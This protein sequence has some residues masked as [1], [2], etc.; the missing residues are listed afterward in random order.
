M[1]EV[2]FLKDPRLALAVGFYG[3]SA[4]DYSGPRKEFFRLCL[5]EIKAK[6]FDNGLKDHL[7][8]DYSTIGLIMVLSTLQNGSVPRLLKEDH[9]Q[10]LF[11]SEEPS[12][13]CISRLRFGFKTLELIKK[14]MVYLTSFTFLDPQKVQPCQEESWLSFSH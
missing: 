5:R 8:N 1:E 11:P 6:Y 9:L 12:N 14:E 10:A 4:E 3:E 7:S 2:Q 13:P